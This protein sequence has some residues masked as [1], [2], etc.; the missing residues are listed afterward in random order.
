MCWVHKEKGMEKE[1]WGARSEIPKIVDEV[2]ISFCDNAYGGESPN[3]VPRLG[4]ERCRAA[5]CA[6][7]GGGRGS[8]RHLA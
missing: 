6:D 7:S 1:S 8:M 2:A 3:P 4:T 5:T